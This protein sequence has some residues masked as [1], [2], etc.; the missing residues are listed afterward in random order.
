MSLIYNGVQNNTFNLDNMD[1][2]HHYEE[3]IMAINVI[4]IQYFT[5][6]L[7]YLKL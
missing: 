3:F 7:N 1:I 6:L 4:Q 2:K 5:K